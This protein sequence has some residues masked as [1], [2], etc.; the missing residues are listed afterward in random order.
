MKRWPCVERN[1]LQR[2]TDSFSLTTCPVWWWVTLHN[3]F[4][5]LANI[6]KHSKPSKVLCDFESVRNNCHESF[7]WFFSIPWTTV[8]KR[9]T[10]HGSRV[11]QTYGNSGSTTGIHRLESI[12]ILNSSITWHSQLK[13]V[14]HPFLLKPFTIKIRWTRWTLSVS[15]FHL[16]L[17]AEVCHWC[18]P[19]GSHYLEAAAG[20]PICGGLMCH[21]SKMRA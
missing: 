4:V 14:S 3:H 6:S 21:A 12:F 9:S 18:R 16:Y 20:G 13:V 19:S 10:Q 15:N 1:H 5:A 11:C 2:K 7:E 17:V 8:T